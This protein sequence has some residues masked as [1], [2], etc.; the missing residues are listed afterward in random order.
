MNYVKALK[1]VVV[2][3]IMAIC[4]A[5]PGEM[6]Q[7]YLSNFDSGYYHTSFYLPKDV[8]QDEMNE[9]ILSTAKNMML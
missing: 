3:I 2:G 7:L 9:E 6:F 1:F 4:L 8:S 5:L